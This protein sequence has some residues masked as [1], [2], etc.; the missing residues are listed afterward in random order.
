MSFADRLLRKRRALDIPGYAG[1][2]L[3]EQIDRLSREGGVS[4][5]DINAPRVNLRDAA[6][7]GPQP[8]P[9]PT[10]FLRSPQPPPERPV[11]LT[12]QNRESITRP[13]RTYNTTLNPEEEQRFEIWKQQNAPNDSGQDYD[14][15]GAF[16]AGVV[17]NANRHWP[18]T[19]KKPNHPTFSDESQYATGSDA[20]RAGS[21]NGGAFE[22][23]QQARPA[24]PSFADRLIRNTSAV[25]PAQAE[26]IQTPFGSSN[27]PF[28]LSRERRTQPRDR[29]AE[30]ADYLRE[31][32]NKPLGWREK[33]GMVS[34]A[35]SR[36]LGGE[37]LQTKRQRELAKAEGQLAQD[38]AV[39][40]Q[41]I[42]SEQGQM[43]P[44][45]LANGQIVMVPAKTAG[46]T[47]SQQQGFSL[48]REQLENHKKR[49][50]GMAVHEAAQDAQRL[51]NSGAADDDDDLKAEVARRMGLPV[52]TRLPNHDKGQIQVDDQG[53]FV[54]ISPKTGVTTSAT[55]QPSPEVPPQPVGSMQGTAEKGRQRRFEQ[56]ETGKDRR[57][58]VQQAGADRRASMRGTTGTTTD[59]ASQRRAAELTG[60]IEQA[61]QA[62][63]LADER[64]KREPNNAT[65]KREREQARAAG[66]AWAVELNNLNAGYE[67][68][69]GTGGYPYYKKVDGQQQPAKSGGQYAGKRISKANVAEYGRRHQMTADEAAEFL[70]KE[71]ATIY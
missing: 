52:S 37:P 30:D 59:R 6:L 10:L 34:Q 15:R 50:E 66:E 41:R 64:L 57:V 35:I 63:A 62:M 17:P 38:V 27:Q 44:V 56:G 8:E 21:W 54:I 25:D 13:R 49:W 28:E 70:R 26:A 33:A 45:T 32:Q 24:V 3:Q 65:A 1:G 53:N 11:M 14:L 55:Q 51:Y 31:L 46:N 61:R 4:S 48:R 29:V 60:K 19:F 2:T 39:E 47:S 20:A 42:A 68:G 40:K 67:A 22:P 71:G 16:K 23:P 43:V 69:P 12:E 58:G 18:D 36:S 7:S 9:Q 5:G